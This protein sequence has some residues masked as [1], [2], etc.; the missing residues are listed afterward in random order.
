MS[1]WQTLNRKLST[2]SRSSSSTFVSIIEECHI[3][4][5]LF[6]GIFHNF[7]NIEAP[8]SV[9]RW[10]LVP[11]WSN[12]RK[13]TIYNTT[14]RRIKGNREGRGIFRMIYSPPRCKDVFTFSLALSYFKISSPFFGCVCC[15]NCC[16][17]KRMEGISTGG[18]WRGKLKNSFHFSF[19]EFFVSRTGIVLTGRRNI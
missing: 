9:F 1:L 8:S 5:Y 18:G 6:D 2:S 11:M 17:I 16:E 4:L 10:S 12:S 19:R 15:V 14:E 13:L 3:T 7:L